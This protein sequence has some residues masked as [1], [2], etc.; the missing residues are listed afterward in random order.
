MSEEDQRRARTLE[1]L[2]AWLILAPIVP[3]SIIGLIVYGAGADRR[4]AS[5]LMLSAFVVFEFIAFVVAS[6]LIER[7]IA[8]RRGTRGV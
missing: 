8:I 4:L 2:A 6:G 7:S 3:S 5:G 1:R